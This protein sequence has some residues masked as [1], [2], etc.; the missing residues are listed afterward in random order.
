MPNRILRDWTDSEK[1]NNLTAD[2]ERFFTRL[3]MKVDD[4]GR[5]PANP[6]LLRSA[7]FPLLIDKIS[8]KDVSQWTVN[9]Q[10][11][12]SQLI[13]VYEV[14]GKRYI[15]I[16]NFRQRLRNQRE[17]YPSPDNGIII[18]GQLTVNCQ[19]DDGLKRNET[20]RNRNEVE[21]QKKTKTVFLPP[22]LPEV[23]EYFKENGFPEITA[24]RAFNYYEAGMWHDGKGNQVRNWKQKMQS[25]WFKE[26]NRLVNIVQTPEPIGKRYREI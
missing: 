26:E 22:S 9:C 8:E 12:D 6:K 1:V 14:D 3:I 21:T 19:S 15:Q 7:L 20:K 13:I 2:A 18:D 10:S 5:F 25:V 17:K 23:I 11:I 16:N 24:K 4:Y